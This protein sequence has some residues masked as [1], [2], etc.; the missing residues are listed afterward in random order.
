MSGL[1]G[2][3]QELQIGW[4]IEIST[5]HHIQNL[6][7]QSDHRMLEPGL[8]NELFRQISEAINAC[9]GIYRQTFTT[10][11]YAAKLSV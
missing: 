11:A 3:V 2:P 8:R 9:G 1:F 5:H 7:T 6:R 4:E 10:H